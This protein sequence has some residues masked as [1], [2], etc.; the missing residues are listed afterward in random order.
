MVADVHSHSLSPVRLKSL[1]PPTKYLCVR[2]VCVLYK[3]ARRLK[4]P[5]QPIHCISKCLSVRRPIII[6]FSYRCSLLRNFV[7]FGKSEVRFIVCPCLCECD[8]FAACDDI[9]AVLCEI[10]CA[11]N[12]MEHR[13]THADAVHRKHTYMRKPHVATLPQRISSDKTR[14]SV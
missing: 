4:N 12:K 14:L 13:I 10:S 5:K 8:S 1:S 6:T 11:K 7:A 3:Y 2:R 9:T